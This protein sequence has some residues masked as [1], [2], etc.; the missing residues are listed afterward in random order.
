M[1]KHAA[2]PE[3]QDAFK[4]GEG[5][6]VE[7]VYDLLDRSTFYYAVKDADGEVSRVSKEAGSI[8]RCF[9]PAPFQHW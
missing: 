7:K 5:E 8:Y 4:Y 1:E 6:A 3:I 9:W 2:V